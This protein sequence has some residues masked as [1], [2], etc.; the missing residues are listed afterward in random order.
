MILNEQAIDSKYWNINTDERIKAA[1]KDTTSLDYIWLGKIFG[2]RDPM[3]PCNYF[4]IY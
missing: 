1:E 3:R 2:R 4:T